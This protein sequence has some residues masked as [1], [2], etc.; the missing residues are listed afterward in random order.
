MARYDK[1]FNFRVAHENL[2]WLKEQAE[3]NRRSLTA[4]MNW[5]LEEMQRKQ[6]REVKA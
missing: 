4:Q 2:E 5:I 1:Q 6:Q 3:K